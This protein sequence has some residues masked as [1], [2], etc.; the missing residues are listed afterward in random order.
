MKE[1]FPDNHALN[2]LRHFNKW[3]NFLFTTN[4]TKRDY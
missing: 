4:E 1:K 3:V 2:N